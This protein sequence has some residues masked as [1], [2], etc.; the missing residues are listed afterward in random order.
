MLEKP[1]IDCMYSIY[2]KSFLSYK[3][4][5]GHIKNGLGNT[6]VT[7]L[8]SKFYRVFER[9]CTFGFNCPQFA[10]ASFVVMPNR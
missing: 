8:T 9:K 6:L 10:G 7:S 3:K 5:S 4:F 2:K 1:G